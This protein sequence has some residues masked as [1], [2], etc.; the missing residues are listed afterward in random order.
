MCSYLSFFKQNVFHVH[1]SD[2]LIYQPDYYETDGSQYSSFRLN[3]DDPTVAGL[4]HR[5]NESYYADDWENIQRKCADRG[6]TIIPEIEA[7]AHALVITEWK[8]ELALETDKHM[9]NLSH[10]E[11]VPTMETIWKAFLPWFHAKTV[12]IGADEYDR[13]LVDDYMGFVNAM[14]DFI[15]TESG[16][17]VRIW[18]YV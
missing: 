5:T 16:K 4:S 3:S 15:H 11:T 17:S 2:N 10:P 14:N 9:L 7:P 8:P 18:G 13:D 12:H 6:V 1:V